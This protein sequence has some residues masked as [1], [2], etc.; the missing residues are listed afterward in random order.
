MG[1]KT[2][3][4]RAA[5]VIHTLKKHQLLTLHTTTRLEVAVTSLPAAAVKQALAAVAVASVPEVA[6]IMVAV[7][8]H[9]SYEEIVER[10]PYWR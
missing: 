4:L 7:A 10:E 1:T 2:Q 3:V 9:Q 8:G 5:V 6:I